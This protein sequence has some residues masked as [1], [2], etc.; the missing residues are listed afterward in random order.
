MQFKQLYKLI[1]KIIIVN[2]YIIVNWQCNKSIDKYCKCII[3]LY[4]KYVIHIIKEINYNEYYFFA[5]KYKKMKRNNTL[6]T[7]NLFR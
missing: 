3:L 7:L 4:I 1:Q 2:T 5:I 6:N